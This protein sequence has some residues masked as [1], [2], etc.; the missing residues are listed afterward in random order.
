MLAAGQRKQGGIDGCASFEAPYED[1][2]RLPKTGRRHW[3]WM[4][5]MEDY[6]LPAMLTRRQG[7]YIGMVAEDR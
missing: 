6:T 5:S 3:K 7:S 2:W 4:G 1:K